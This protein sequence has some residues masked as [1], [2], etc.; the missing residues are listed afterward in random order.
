MPQTNSSHSLDNDSTNLSTAALLHER[1]AFR[2]RQVEQLL[3]K[4]LASID[5]QSPLEQAYSY[6]LTN[7]G[8]RFRP[9]LVLMVAD[10]IN[11]NADVRQAALAVECFHTASLI[12]DDL[13]CMDNDALRRDKPATH[14][15]FGESTAL[16]ASY[17]LIAAGYELLANNSML[18]AQSP[19]THLAQASQICAL[20]VK[21]VSVNTGLAGATGGQFLD[22]FPPDLSPSTLLEVIKKK[23]ATLFEISF[24]LGWLYGGGAIDRLPTVSQAAIHFGM[25]FQIADDLG[26]I[27]QDARNERKVNI[28]AVCGVEAAISM[29]AEA[30]DNYQQAL[31]LLNIDGSFEL[32]QLPSLLINSR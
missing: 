7:G 17:A 32:T 19:H 14:I 29:L 24:V 28:A 5:P 21:N 31:K 9:I 6:A 10:A 25:A 23:T 12:A 4:H 27:E 8:K 18:L 13:P 26:D 16:M 20:A 11:L 30:I 2:R 22:L 15:V 3:T 1:I